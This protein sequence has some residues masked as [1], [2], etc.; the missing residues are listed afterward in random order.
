MKPCPFCAEEIQDEAIKCRH[1][2]TMLEEPERHDASQAVIPTAN[3]AALMGYYAG[4]FSIIP[5]FGLLL[6]P[7]ALVLGLVGRSKI[8]KD[9]R[10]PGT[11]HAWVGIVMGALVTLAHLGLVLMI[12]FGR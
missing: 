1:C 9:P 12:M 10:L 11:A 6:G 3:P 8:T 2:Q 4:C 7:L 5:F